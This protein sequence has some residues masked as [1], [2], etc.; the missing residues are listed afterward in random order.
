MFSLTPIEAA[1]WQLGVAA[2]TKFSVE[3]FGTI[4]FTGVVIFFLIKKIQE[5]LLMPASGADTTDIARAALSYGLRVIIGLILLRT[6]STE[7]FTPVDISG[8]EWQSYQFVAND[9][10]YKKLSDSTSGLHWYKV[11]YGAAVG[12]SKH[13]SKIAAGIFSDQSYHKSPDLMFKLLTSTASVSLDDPNVTAKLDEFTQKCSDTGVGTVTDEAGSMGDLMNLEDPDCMQRYRDLQSQLK[14][15][16]KNTMP[17]V[18]KKAQRSDSSELPPGLVGFTSSELIENKIIGSALIGYGRQKVSSGKDSINTNIRELGITDKGDHFWYSL[19]KITSAGGLA[20]LIGS[21]FAGKGEA[22]ATINRNEARIIYNNLLNLI[23]AFKGYAKAFIALLFL[24]AA[25][26]LSLGYTQPA[27]WWAKVVLLD[28]AYEPLST[29]NYEL[30]SMLLASSDIGW[31]FGHLSKDP[32]ALM[33][34]ATIDQELVTYQTT[35][36]LVQFVIAAMCV[37][38]AVKAGFAVRSMS[39][40]QGGGMM[41]IPGAGYIARGIGADVRSA[42]N[43]FRGTKV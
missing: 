2:Q 18:L 13:L 32:M 15:W 7:V 12:V 24:L 29:L 40:S 20:G 34:A 30:S 27:F 17:A 26:G 14:D 1:I 22:E 39:F 23:P 33:G 28:M 16:A 41:N 4:I 9:Q 25:A 35:Y 42:G 6:D 3:L 5:I 31:A 43:R 36:F 8:R 10:R 21:V 38:G 37:A 11:I 19:Q